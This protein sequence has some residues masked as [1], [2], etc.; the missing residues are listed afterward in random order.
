MTVKVFVPE[1]VALELRVMP[2]PPGVAA[3]WVPPGNSAELMA[4]LVSP[5]CA[6]EAKMPAS[7]ALPRVA[8]VLP[9]VVPTL[10]AV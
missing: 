9:I 10:L 4:T 8:V 5:A 1:A 6:I 7:V 3:N 2:N